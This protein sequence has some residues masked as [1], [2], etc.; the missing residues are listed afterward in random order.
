MSSARWCRASAPE[1]A[2]THSAQERA[3]EQCHRRH[4]GNTELCTGI[5]PRPIRLHSPPLS[6]Q[7][8]KSQFPWQLAQ[9]RHCM[10]NW[11]RMEEKWFSVLH[12]SGFCTKYQSILLLTHL[13]LSPRFS[14][15][16]TW[17]V[18]AVV[19]WCEWPFHLCRGGCRE[20]P[21]DQWKC[22]IQLSGQRRVLASL[23]CETSVSVY[24]IQ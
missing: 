12:C 8:R 7:Q 14:K 9:S 21:C 15:P 4:H 18:K 1:E 24:I 11:C 2:Y 17:A 5:Y 16:V 6:W 20:K 13:T 3:R 19:W 10:I 23:F 22:F